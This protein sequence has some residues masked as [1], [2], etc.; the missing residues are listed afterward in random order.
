MSSEKRL[1]VFDKKSLHISPLSLDKKV[2]TSSVLSQTE[3][4]LLVHAKSIIPDKSEEEEGDSVKEAKLRLADVAVTA[5]E[6]RRVGRNYKRDDECYRLRN[7]HNSGEN[8]INYGREGDDRL[9]ALLLDDLLVS[10]EL[11]ED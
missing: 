2:S 11:V 5:G 7:E 3:N 1:F 10:D 9:P 4:T 8:E 6:N